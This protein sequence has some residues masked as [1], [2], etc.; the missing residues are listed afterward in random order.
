MVH[1][2]TGAR[3]AGKTSAV[4]SL[5]L[6]LGGCGI[7]SVKDFTAEG[8]RGY[9]ALC[10][11]T[12]EVRPLARTSHHL[13]RQ[14]D[15]FYS[16]GRFSFS[17]EGLLFAS[18][19][20][21]SAAVSSCTPVFL[22]EAGRLELEGKGFACELRALLRSEKEVYITCRNKFFDK[23]RKEYTIEEYREIDAQEFPLF[24]K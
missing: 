12:G 10:L 2:I 9:N 3:D 15:Q 1:I 7:A 4:L 6:Q 22:D 23:M 14:W 18:S 17:R 21:A 8:F 13:P 5:H 24:Y 16:F 20:L 11:E 19:V